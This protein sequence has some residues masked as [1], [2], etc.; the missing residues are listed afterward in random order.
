MDKFIQIENIATGH[1]KVSEA[2]VIGAKQ[3]MG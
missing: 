1:E 2:A 3:K